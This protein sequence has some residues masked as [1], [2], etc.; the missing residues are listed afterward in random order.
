MLQDFLKA[1]IPISQ[2]VADSATER[3]YNTFGVALN[4]FMKKQDM[5]GFFQMSN[6]TRSKY[7]YWD[8]KTV[9]DR[10][11]DGNGVKVYHDHVETFIVPVPVIY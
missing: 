11:L 9:N 3:G 6:N 2:A 10:C 8:A 5:Y 1:G 7:F 4:Y